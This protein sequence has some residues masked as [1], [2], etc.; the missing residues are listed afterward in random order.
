MHLH[1]FR[2]E[3]DLQGEFIP[4]GGTNNGEFATLPSCSSSTRYEVFVSGITDS[5]WELLWIS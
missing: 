1:I 2:Q 5:V 3:A 4:V